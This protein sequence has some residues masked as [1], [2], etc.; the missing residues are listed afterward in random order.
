KPS[1]G[2]GFKEEEKGFV[3]HKL[4][5]GKGKGGAMPLA[6]ML[7]ASVANGMEKHPVQ[8]LKGYEERKIFDEKMDAL[9][10]NDLYEH[11]L[12]PAEQHLLRLCALYREGTPNAH[13]VALNEAVKEKDV[14][15][16][17]V[18]RC[19]LNPNHTEN[20][21]FLHE[22]IAQLTRRRID[23]F[24]NKEEY[25]NDHEV[26]ANAWLAQLKMSSQPSLPNIQATIEAF[27]HLLE[28][29]SYE[30]FYELSDRLLR[31]NVASHLQRA[32]KE[33][34]KK[35]NHKA[36]RHVLELLVRIEPREPRFH[37]FLGDTIERINGRGDEDA[38]KHYRE[39]YRLVPDFPQHLNVLGRCLMARR[40]AGE[41][42]DIVEKLSDDEYETVM[43]L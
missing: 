28:S 2:W 5:E 17:L 27:F 7:L 6:M 40:E 19:L 29:E 41:F 13:A 37:R 15:W 31:K 12:P 24:K 43:S 35:H 4:G 21:Y 38:L 36:D 22:V 33:L 32:S 25:W 3:H 16:Q 18:R 10:F 11:V 1:V 34:S 20:W 30:G 39:A 26:I 14:F 8:V 23:K 42:V 9:L